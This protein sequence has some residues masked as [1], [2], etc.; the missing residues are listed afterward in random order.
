MKSIISFFK[1]SFFIYSLFLLMF[2]SCDVGLG[3]EVDLEGATVTVTSHKDN[4]YVSRVFRLMGTAY[5]KLGVTSIT[6][7]FDEADLHYRMLEDG[8]WQKKN[9]NSDWSIMDSS[10]A[11]SIIK[12][13]KVIWSVEVNTSESTVQTGSTYNFSIVAYDKMKNTNKNSKVDGSLLVDENIPFVSINRPEL[14][15][16]YFAIE[17]LFQK[18]TLKDGNVISKLLNGE[19]KVDGR[20]D[21]AF[22]FRELRIEFDD[23]TVDSLNVNSENN[24]ENLIEVSTEEISNKYTFKRNKL[25]FSK[26]LKVGEDNIT[27]LRTWIVNVKPSD[28]ISE[29]R[30]TELL[31]GKHIIRVVAT[32]IS[33]SNAWERKVLGYFVW[34]PE[35][36]KPWINLYSGESEE[37]NASNSPV[38]PSSKIYGLVQDDDGILTLSYKLFKKNELNEFLSVKEGQLTLSEENAK[39]SDF[40]I[41]VP[42]E[43][44]IY[45]LEVNT[46][47]LYDNS[48]SVVKYF[49]ILDVKP[50]TIEILSPTENSSIL[51]STGKIKFV[52]NIIDDGNVQ[53]VKLVYLNP[54]IN[55]PENK[56]KFINS[57]EK[58]WDLQ[59]GKADSLGNI[60]YSVNLQEPVFDK[61]NKNNIYSFE[62]EFDLF[63]DLGIGKSKKLGS[64][65][66]IF[67]AVDSSNTSTVSLY[68][69]TGDAESPNLTIDSIIINND[70]NYSFEE[71]NV[72]TLPPLKKDDILTVRGTWSD[73]STDILN[74]PSKINDIRFSFLDNDFD[75]QKNDDGTWFANITDVPSSSG[76]ILASIEDFGGN[77]KRVNK[78]IFIDSSETRLDRISSDND[79]G[80]Y[81]AN[82]NIRINLDFTKNVIFEGNNPSLILNNGGIANYS[83]GNGTSKVV[84]E[85]VVKNGDDIQKLDVKTIDSSDCVWKDSSTK[86]EFEVEVPVSSNTLNSRNIRVDTILPKINSINVVSSAGYYKSNSSIILLLEFN[87]DVNITNVNNLELKFKHKNNG[88]DVKTSLASSTGSKYVLFT[89]NVSNGDNSDNLSIDS[90]ISEDVIVL[91]VAGN[92]LLDWS[93]PNSTFDKTL[94]IDTDKPSVPTVKPNWNGNIVIDENG[95]SFSVTGE[96]GASIEYSLNGGN[97]WQVYSS[98]VELINNGS[99]IITTRQTDKAG[100]VSDCSSPI[101]L[102]ID[103]GELLSKISSETFNGVYSSMSEINIIK[104]YIEFRKNVTINSGAY[105]EL[106]VKNKSNENITAKL[107]ECVSSDYT[108]NKFT[109]DYCIQEGDYI[110]SDTGLLDVINLS[111][112]SVKVDDKDISIQLPSIDSKSGKRFVENREI[113][114]LTGNPKILDYKLSGQGKETILVLE[115]DREVYK[116]SGTITFT[117]D[118][119]SGNY[120]V[121]VVLSVNEYNELK[122]SIS[123]IDD[124]YKPGVNGAELSENGNS[125]IPITE[126]K[127]ILDFSKDD[128]DSE[129]LEK[130][131]LA[132]KHKVTVPIY[133]SVVSVDNKKVTV[134]LGSTYKLPVMGADYNVEISEGAFIDNVQNENS[135][136]NTKLTSDGVE[137]PVIRIEKKGYTITWTDKTNK[138]TTSSD[139]LMPETAKMKINCRTPG[140]EIKYAKQ[141]K[142]SEEKYVNDT[143]FHD[144]KTSDVEIPTDPTDLIEYEFDEIEL[145]DSNLSFDSAKGK[146][147]AVVAESLKNGFT[148]KSYE[149]AVRTVLKFEISSGAGY[150]DNQGNATTS[151]VENGKSLKMENLKIWI[152]GGD[153]PSGGNSLETFPLSWGECS[154]YKLMKCQYGTTRNGNVRGNWYWITWDLSALAY[155]GFV[156]GDVPSDAQEKGPSIW[157]AGECSWNPLKTHYILYPGETLR[158]QLAEGHNNGGRANYFFRL[159]NKGSR[160]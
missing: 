13:N 102:S 19:I 83:E 69:Y 71:N 1:K 8:T 33:N 85:Y 150:D 104:G 7:D 143:V 45:K 63:D 74:D 130:F 117:Q 16:N 10:K 34:W 116:K 105:V 109:F 29:E 32:S 37:N 75:V 43:S 41:S 142:N 153:S 11:N 72:P 58:D 114:I 118:I 121:P 57:A 122:V 129:L 3:D 31:S 77:V 25:Y 132:N 23:G 14:Y 131:I 135:A 64:Q 101:N 88:S 28:W 66:F 61:Q 78:T 141:E 151:I 147:I 42:S 36:D 145:G 44:G 155:H 67:K 133:S 90:V 93:L 76:V 24:R 124:Y 49:E 51:N 81:K 113:S 97:S 80:A 98:Q 47:D 60:V 91:D 15:S 53:S 6:I 50:P 62:I 27:D 146:K 149:Y 4:D 138:P 103:K 48:D 17:D 156:A 79:D 9:S 5:D 2:L 21:N 38:Y 128:S 22:S 82:D 96:D 127:Y 40:D 87:E 110:D 119:Q 144:T 115:F 112:N 139:V 107:I 158:M 160:E 120:K 12:D 123:N 106:N 46:T 18:F 136:F 65:E 125:L 86:K 95:T 140:A 157:Y 54:N 137:P 59:N 56:I 68:T 152:Q 111:F 26:T 92:Q 35:A 94:V 154:K 52:G 30:N 39:S 134:N 108:S 84:F 148:E 126:K 159:K 55:T 89:Y 100:N 73:N 70:S 99:Y 20:Q